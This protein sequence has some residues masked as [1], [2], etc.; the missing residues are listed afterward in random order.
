[1][2][3]L[4]GTCGYPHPLAEI[5][6]WATVVSFAAAFLLGEIATIPGTGAVGCNTTSSRIDPVG[7]IDAL[8]PHGASHRLLE[9]RLV[10]WD[11]SLLL[12]Q[13]RSWRPG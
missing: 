1:M 7:A 4:A 8:L 2:F 13:N 11:L 10:A 6:P 5:A 9:I 12:G 3:F